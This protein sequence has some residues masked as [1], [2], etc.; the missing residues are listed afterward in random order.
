MQPLSEPTQRL[1]DQRLLGNLSEAELL[2]FNRRL[3]AEPEFA[4]QWREFQ[5]LTSGLKQHFA[6]EDA[7]SRI[8]QAA[9]ELEAAGFFKQKKQQPGTTTIVP[10]SPVRRYLA[11]AAAMAVVLAAVWFIN[12]PDQPDSEVLFASNFQPDQ[13]QLSSTLDELEKYGLGEADATS[14]QALSTALGLIEQQQYANA[15]P[16]LKNWLSAPVS[17]SPDAARNQNIARYYL[18]QAL[19]ATGIT[20]QETEQLLTT[21]LND[22]AFSSP[23]EARWLLALCRIKNKHFDAAVP[24]LQ[25]VATSTSTHAPAAAKLLQQLR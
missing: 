4:Q 23:D 3:E 18:A 25:T 22:P 15:I 19:M 5:Q 14:R 21:I 1:F 6:E 17:G 10:L 8:A 12:K 20:S 2:E 9:T 13:K 7:R 11:V 24:L 16:L